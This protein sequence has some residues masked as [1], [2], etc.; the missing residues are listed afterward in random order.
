MIKKIAILSFISFLFLISCE[1]DEYQGETADFGISEYYE[2][3]LF[4][5]SDTAI[6]TKTLNYDF[7][8]YAVEQKSFAK[9]KW[10]DQNQKNIENNNIRF[11]IN[12]KQVTSN[13]FQISSN[14]GK[15][16]L[17]LGVQMLPDFPEGYTSGFLSISNNDLDV[18]NNLDLSTS[19]DERLFKW[20]A[21]HK[22]VMNPL[23]K[24]LMWVG[25]LILALLVVW[26]LVFRNRLHPKF[27][28]GKIQIL[29]P[30]FGGVSFNQNTKLIVFTSSNQKQSAFNRI[31]TG[32][33]IYEVNPIYSIDIFLRPGRAN[34]IKIKLPVGATIK[35]P[36]TQLDKFSEYKIILNQN[37]IKIQYS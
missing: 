5:K 26:F 14:A 16:K 8:D 27:K 35:P 20:E 36:V 25:I 23:K 32:K 37:I 12:G 29:S 34:K 1:K 4:V 3:F 9:I 17:K 21:T 10:V 28:R 15:G 30:Y 2:P 19:S 33:I 6:L 31:F 24:A 18:V 22:I 7:N 13:E 11:W